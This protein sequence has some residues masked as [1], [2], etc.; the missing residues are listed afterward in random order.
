MRGLSG[1]NI[2]LVNR[3]FPK[4]KVERVLR[5]F[6][7]VHISWPG[8]VYLLQNKT[9]QELNLLSGDVSVGRG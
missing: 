1:R 9:V 3:V 7:V 4:G 8:G 2:L 5:T 6:F